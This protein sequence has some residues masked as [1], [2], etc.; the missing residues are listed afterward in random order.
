[1]RGTGS[2]VAGSSNRSSST[3]NWRGRSTTRSKQGR[4]P[5]WCGCGCRPMLR[6]SGTEKHPNKPFFGC[7]NYNTSGKTWCGLFVWAD[8]VQEELSER[9]ISGDDDGDRKKNFAWRM[10]KME[11]DIRNLKFITHVLGFGFLVVVVFVGMVLLKGVGTNFRKFV[12][13]EAVAEL[14][15]FIGSSAVEGVVGGDLLLAGSLAGLVAGSPLTLV[16]Y[17]NFKLQMK[18]KVP[19][20][21]LDWW[22]QWPVI[23]TLFLKG[24]ARYRIG[25]VLVCFLVRLH[26]YEL[27]AEILRVL[28]HYG[29]CSTSM[30]AWNPYKSILQPA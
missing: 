13:R 27:V 29:Q 17:T 21:P 1:M 5:D 22:C 23:L 11:A 6:W 18:T 25:V 4:V 2:H 26:G 9:A 10:G 12:N 19:W 28:V 14:A 7:P 3:E 30:N 15:P 16:N 24:L 20:L 8:C